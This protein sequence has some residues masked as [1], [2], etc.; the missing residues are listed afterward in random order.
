MTECWPPFIITAMFPGILITL[1][2]LAAGLVAAVFW[3]RSQQRQRM[4]VVREEAERIRTRAT[5]EGAALKRQAEV[6][7]REEALARRHALESEQQA[8]EDLLGTREAALVEQLGIVAAE[9]EALT[10]REET[11]GEAEEEADKALE[12]VKSIRA[13]AKALRSK[14]ENSVEEVAGLTRIECKGALAGALVEEAQAEAADVLRNL[15]TEPSGTTVRA[16][17]RIM[18]ISIGRLEMRNAPGRQ[19]YNVDA[20][21]AGRALLESPE[22]GVLPALE[23]LLGVTCAWINN[24]ETL[25]IDTGTGVGR[26][27]AR[28]AL[29]KIL[30]QRASDPKRVLQLIEAC[31]KEVQAEVLAY[32]HRAFNALGLPPAAPEV[33][34]LV[35]RLHFR[36]SYTQNQWEHVMEASHLAGLMAAELGLD[37]KLARRA[38]LL[39][40]IGKALTH[41]VDGSHALLGGEIARRNGEPPEVCAA[42]EEHH[43]EKPISSVYSLLVVAADS[44]SGARPGARR[45]LV[46]TYG[47][48]IYELERLASAFR[49]VEGAHAVQAGREVRVFVDEQRVNDEAA[50]GLATEIAR[51]ISDELTFPGQIRVTVIREFSAVEIAN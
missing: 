35:G 33:L 19:S 31:Q 6:T 3:A 34:D 45:E 46:E 38:T 30:T 5:A 32:G 47:E 43:D 41:E 7:A 20:D 24:G 29:D 50:A 26:I 25:R 17:K 23:S 14:A 18:G 36:T 2:A 44:I 39:H 42:I 9:E 8:S 15:E 13:E 27:T 37:V 12:R 16:G 40:D 51:K 28:R 4:A 1:L 48:R 22:A 49:G 21:E 11:L 10:S